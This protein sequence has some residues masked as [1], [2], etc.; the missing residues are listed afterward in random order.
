VLSHAAAPAQPPRSA[1]AAEADG[2]DYAPGESGDGG[3]QD[4]EGTLEEEEEAA[5]ADADG[6][7]VRAPAPAG[8]AAP[9]SELAGRPRDTCVLHV[10]TSPHACRIRGRACCLWPALHAWACCA[11]HACCGQHSA[12]LWAAQR[13][14]AAHLSLC[15]RR[16]RQA[17]VADEVAALAD[18]ADMP[19]EELMAR[20]GLRKGP[21]GEL[22]AG[23]PRGGSEPSA[24][25]GSEDA[26]GDAAPGL[27]WRREIHLSD[28]RALV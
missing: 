24:G 18:E 5:A 1:D 4:D 25:A 3:S 8:A 17:A 23:A 9:A 19:L 16:P 28:A 26:P 10:R 12:L 22:G 6:H 15:A 13:A 11:A 21:A 7:R 27:A 2:Q 20:Y 14:R